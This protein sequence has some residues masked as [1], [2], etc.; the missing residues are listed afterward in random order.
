MEEI[1]VE[2]KSYPVYADEEC[3]DLE[4]CDELQAEMRIR[5]AAHATGRLRAFD[6]K[7]RNHWLIYFVDGAVEH[8]SC[9]IGYCLPDRIGPPLC[10]W[11][12]GRMLSDE[13]G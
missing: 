8:C 7:H 4:R 10:E 11:I 6:L 2:D 1:T 12:A 3:V 5:T 9:T 13:P